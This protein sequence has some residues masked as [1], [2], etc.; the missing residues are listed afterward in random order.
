MSEH[1]STREG[2]VVH[3]CIPGYL[4]L[5][6]LLFLLGASGN[7]A[8]AQGPDGDRGSFFMHWGYNRAYYTS[9]DIHFTGADYD[10]T[11]YNVTA[12]DRPEPFGKDYFNITYI[13]VPQYNYRF[14][15]HFRDRWSLSLG[16]DHMKYVVIQDQTVMMDGYTNSSQMPEDPGEQGARDLLLKSEVLTYEHSDG[17]N[18]LSVDLD[19]YDRIWKSK[20][21]K[22]RLRIYEGIHAGPVIP[23]SDVRL[24]GTG[25][26]NHFNV[27]G[28]GMGA[29]V[30]LHFTFLKHFYIRNALKAG[31]IDL[32]HVLTTGSKEEQA[33][34]HFW[35]VQH[36]IVVGAQFHLGK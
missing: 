2:Y 4:T 28:F 33:S 14:G 23:R 20:S 24:F 12:Q 13:W 16:L 5:I 21:G 25:I 35:F 15:W 9:S 34:Q 17:L 3:T 29:Q 36:A 30:G 26:N 31:W 7:V 1:R 11:L 8:I 6:L 32:P 22:Q 10:F 27:A 18:L 19:H